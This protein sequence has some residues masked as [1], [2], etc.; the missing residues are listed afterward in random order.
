L[1]NR[2]ST[3]RYRGRRRSQI[4]LTSVCAVSRVLSV[5]VEANDLD[6]GIAFWEAV[7]GVRHSAILTWAAGP[8]PRSSNSLMARASS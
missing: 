2:V 6:D 4:G 3:S 5:S 7:L 1:V 8:V